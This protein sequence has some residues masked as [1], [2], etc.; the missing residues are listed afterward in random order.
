M[1]FERN[2]Q[3]EALNNLQEAL[4]VAQQNI[5]LHDLEDRVFALQS[6]LFANLTTD[7]QFDLIVTNP[8]Y[9]DAEDFADMP[10]EYRNEPEL[11]LVSGHDGLD[12]CREIL[13]RSADY[14]NEDGLLVCEVGNSAG[15]LQDQ[16]PQVPFTW[17]EFENGGFGIFMLTKAELMAHRHLF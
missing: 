7:Q 16:Y 1:L 13:R 2:R 6:D 10:E 4:A 3:E 11:A 5:A 9:V 8:P 17:L 12:A 14:L 15:A